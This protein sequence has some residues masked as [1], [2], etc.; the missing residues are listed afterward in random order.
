[1]FGDEQRDVATGTFLCE[2]CYDAMTDQELPADKSPTGMAMAVCEACQGLR[3]VVRWVCGGDFEEA[4]LFLRE[5]HMEG[6]LIRW[7]P[8]IVVNAESLKGL[9]KPVVYL[10]GS[11]EKREDWL[12]IDGALRACHARCYPG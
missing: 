8:K 12:E 7:A 5:K 6:T 4:Q 3:Q 2:V 11:Y 1:M 10:V 9:D